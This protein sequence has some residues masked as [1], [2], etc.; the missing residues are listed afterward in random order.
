MF[1]I[2][3]HHASDVIPFDKAKDKIREQLEMEAQ[4]KSVEELNGQLR[5]KAHIE[6]RV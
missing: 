3:E 6:L 2:I 4:V 5:A 1:K